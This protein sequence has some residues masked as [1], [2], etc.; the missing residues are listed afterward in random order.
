MDGQALV[1][2]QTKVVPASPGLHNQSSVGK[3]TNTQ[4]LE[5]LSSGA[6]SSCG[7]YAHPSLALSPEKSEQCVSHAMCSIFKVHRLGHHC[8]TITD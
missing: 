3:K 6:K 2:W 4:S 5:I 1:P 7:N 8:V